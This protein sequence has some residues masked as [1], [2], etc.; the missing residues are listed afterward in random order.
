M[1]GFEPRVT[2]TFANLF[3]HKKRRKRKWHC[4]DSNPGSLKLLQIHF[5]TKKKK[6]KMALPGFEPRVTETFGNS[7]SHKQKEEKEN[8]IAGIRTQGH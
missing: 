8:G 7:F 2:E 6:K 4:R 3:S 1:P 5:P